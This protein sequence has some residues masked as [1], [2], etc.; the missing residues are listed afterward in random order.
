M[1]PQVAQILP[2]SL[3]GVAATT[4]SKFSVT[5]RRKS[6]QELHKEVFRSDMIRGSDD[7]GS[8][9]HHESVHRPQDIK[10][11]R[12]NRRITMTRSP[13]GPAFHKPAIPPALPRMSS[14]TPSLSTTYYNTDDSHPTNNFDGATV[15]QMAISSALHRSPTMSSPPGITLA[16]AQRALVVP[17]NSTDSKLHHGSDVGVN[18]PRMA[19]A[20]LNRLDSTGNG[21]ELIR[22]GNHGNSCTA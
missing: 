11:Q 18:A 19:L 5:R 13:T 22:G 6:H 1:G 3:T 8:D 17:P 15:H 4:M 2:Q 16:A 7:A 20:G 14:K 9:I 10:S 12:D 21:A